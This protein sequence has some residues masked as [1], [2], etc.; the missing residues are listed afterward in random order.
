MLFLLF[1]RFVSLNW[2]NPPT[3]SMYRVFL[4]PIVNVYNTWYTIQHTR[5]TTFSCIVYTT[6]S[7]QTQLW[8]Y[9][10]RSIDELYQ[11]QRERER[12]SAHIEPRVRASIDHVAAVDR[13]GALHVVAPGAQ[14]VDLELERQTRAIRGAP[15]LHQ[16]V[17]N[18]GG[19]GHRG[20]AAGQGM[21][22][23]WQRKQRVRISCKSIKPKAE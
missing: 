9:I 19:G 4:E 20:E 17:C 3:S 16:S 12:E 14:L 13:V 11:R 23:S 1:A 5:Y 22:S 7:I 8:W 2:K 6:W 18:G 21:A 10:I 15:A